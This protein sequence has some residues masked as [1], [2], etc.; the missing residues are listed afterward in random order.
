MNEKGSAYSQVQ[1]DESFWVN[2]VWGNS[3]KNNPTNDQTFL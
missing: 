3:L 1:N 2:A